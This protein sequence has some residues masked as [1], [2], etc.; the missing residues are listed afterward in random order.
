MHAMFQPH[1]EK[2]YLFV[3]PFTVASR[4]LEFQRQIKRIL[5]RGSKDSH[6]NIIG[7]NSAQAASIHSKFQRIFSLNISEPSTQ[8]YVLYPFT[9]SGLGSTIQRLVLS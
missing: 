1:Q 2:S 7:K 6:M 4:I 9:F 5:I 8:T 3:H